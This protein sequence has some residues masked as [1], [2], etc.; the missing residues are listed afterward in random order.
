[1]LNI[2]LLAGKLKIVASYQQICT[3]PEGIENNNDT[4]Y[5]GKSGKYKWEMILDLD[6]NATLLTG[7]KL[8]STAPSI[9]GSHFSFHHHFPNQLITTL[10]YTPFQS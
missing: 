1:M 7:S 3:T 10:N 6:R 8:V 4:R 2:K 5:E 9:I